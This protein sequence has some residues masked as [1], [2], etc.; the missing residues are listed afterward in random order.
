MR[1]IHRVLALGS[2]LAFMGVST[3]SCVDD[4]A[5][6]DPDRTATL[7]VT[8][9]TVVHKTVWPQGW[10]G[11]VATYTIAV[12]DSG[13]ALVAAWGPGDPAGEPITI[14]EIPYGTYTVSATGL[15]GADALSCV[16]GATIAAGEEPGVVVDAPA[17]TVTLE[18]GPLVGPAHA[19]VTGWLGLTVEWPSDQGVSRVARDHRRVEAADWSSA[20]DFTTFQSA[21]GWTEVLVADDLVLGSGA[22][23]FRVRLY[24]AADA[25]VATA[26]EVVNVYGNYRTVGIITLTEGDFAPPVEEP[27]DLELRVRWSDGGTRS[28]YFVG[29]FNGWDIGAAPE[30]SFTQPSGELV[31]GGVVDGPFEF[32]MCNERDYGTCWHW[33]TGEFSYTFIGEPASYA[34]TFPNPDDKAQLRVNAAPGDHVRVVIDVN[35]LT[36]TV[37]ANP[38]DD[39][40]TGSVNVDIKLEDPAPAV[41]FTLACERSGEH[42]G[43]SH[44]GTF[45]AQATYT[46]YLH[47]ALIDGAAGQ[48]LSLALA[49]L[50]AGQRLTLVVSDPPYA[51]SAQLTLTEALLGG[52]GIVWTY[53]VDFEGVSETKT[54]YASGTVTLSGLDW[55][56]TDALIGTAA[57]D[58][59]NGAR[60]ARMRGHGTSSMTMLESKPN[61]LGT[62]T[63]LYRRYGSEAQVSWVVQVS[64]DGGGAW[65][66]VGAPFTA[67]AT[68][69]AQT[70]TAEVNAAGSVRVRIKREVED[71]TVDRRLNIDDIKM[72]DFP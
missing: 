32:K 36:I 29:D 13:G 41:P 54:S 7:T 64:T 69:D 23:L 3:A 55:D 57:A 35:L 63:F 16:D 46:W 51:H 25:L 71:G 19:D 26:M 70:F 4:T 8:V 34:P 15:C 27:G 2:V 67:P 21:G 47:G 37:I 72:S 58:F 68:D 50:T 42:L 5:P 10:A 39:P 66:P 33:E 60:S 28:L 24:D 48:T 65:S 40:E 38:P 17:V 22:H 6:P 45:S 52:E 53:V 30:L 11:S 56:M 49:G 18:L 59:K 61:G 44:D 1:T 14:P 31:L 12:H 43:C 62:L 9:E 20:T